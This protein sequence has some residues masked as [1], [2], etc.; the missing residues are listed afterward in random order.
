[1]SP[2]QLSPVITPRRASPHGPSTAAESKS[3]AKAGPITIDLTA[4]DDS[5]DEMEDVV[6]VSAPKAPPAIVPPPPDSYEDGEIPDDEDATDELLTE[7]M[8]LDKPASSP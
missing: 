1:M 3:H 2:S 6:F 5:D 4:L 8:L 7:K